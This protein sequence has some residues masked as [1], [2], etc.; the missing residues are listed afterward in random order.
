MSVRDL[1]QAIHANLLI[2]KTAALSSCV[3][4]STATLTPLNC[5][6]NIFIGVNMLES[7]TSTGRHP[8]D[9][10]LA[11]TREDFGVGH[12]FFCFNLEAD[13]GHSGNVSNLWT[14][15]CVFL[16]SYT[17]RDLLFKTN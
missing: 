17:K 13:E 7:I 15:L 14:T 8:K 10:P 11:T 16:I 5:S 4:M 3:C 9:R 6:R 1:Q 12:S 2:L